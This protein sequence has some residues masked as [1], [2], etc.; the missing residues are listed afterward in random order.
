MSSRKRDDP[1]PE[2]LCPQWEQWKTDCLGLAEVKIS[3]CFRPPE[4]GEVVRYEL[5]H[6]SDGST[7]GYGQC[8]YLRIIGEDKV[9]CVLVAGK[10]RVAPLKLLTIPRLELTAAYVSPK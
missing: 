4:F 9:H 2:E 6:F 7:S 1:L 5:H 8:S 10:A 3:I